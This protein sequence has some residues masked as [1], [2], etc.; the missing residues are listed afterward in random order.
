MIATWPTPL[1]QDDTGMGEIPVHTRAAQEIVR[2]ALQSDCRQLL[3]SITV[4]SAVQ[5]TPLPRPRLI[6]E[7]MIKRLPIG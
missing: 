5:Q 6:A 2:F 3:P 7:P 1:F 4:W